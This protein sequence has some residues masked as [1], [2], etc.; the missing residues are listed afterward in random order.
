LE[1]ANEI[2][3]EIARHDG[4]NR[5]NSI[6]PSTADNSR[7]ETLSQT[8]HAEFPC[9]IFLSIPSIKIWITDFLSQK[10]ENVFNIRPSEDDEFI[11]SS[12]QHQSNTPDDGTRT[13]LRRTQSA[14]VHGLAL[15]VCPDEL[16][17]LNLFRIRDRMDVR[18]PRKVPIF[19][20]SFRKIPSQRHLRQLGCARIRRAGHTF[21]TP[22]VGIYRTVPEEMP[23]T[24]RVIGGIQ[25]P[26]PD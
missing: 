17:N 6:L 26:A 14:K 25:D 16:V 3:R 18:T 13:S 15:I 24:V 4:R 19:S 2:E 8:D 9:I 22:F 10:K 23:M 21:I 5:E 1:G 7:S 11:A 12:I 20:T